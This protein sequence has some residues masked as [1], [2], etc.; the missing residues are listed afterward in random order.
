ARDAL[1]DRLTRMTANT[2]REKLRD[3]DVEVRRAAALA[4]AMK[5]DR[6]QVPALIE[7]LEDREPLVVR[8]ARAALKS[9]TEQ[10][11]GPEADATRAERT[12]AVAA[13]K[14]WWAKNG[15]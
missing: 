6:A 10:D 14:A 2:L 12:K 8:A 11:F 13:W 1:A 3:E 15:K 4:C 9:L 7:L 5:D